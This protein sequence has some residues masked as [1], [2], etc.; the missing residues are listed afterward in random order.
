M[1]SLYWAEGFDASSLRM[2]RPSAGPVP[3]AW[4]SG[5][6]MCTWS[7]VMKEQKVPEALDTQVCSSFMCPV[8]ILLCPPL[9]C[10]QTY[11]RTCGRGACCK[12]HLRGR[13]ALGMEEWGN[14]CESHQEGVTQQI[15]CASTHKREP[16]PYL[17][18]LC[19]S[20]GRPA[21][22]WGLGFWQ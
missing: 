22:A 18:S 13:W 16:A 6:S 10:G 12:P 7:A 21:C 11:L 17:G 15:C 3:P 1:L 14:T 8:T 4:A 20:W 19:A 9:R 5:W 2:F